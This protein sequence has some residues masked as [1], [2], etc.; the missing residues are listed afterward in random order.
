MI[1]QLLQSGSE[2]SILLV[3][4]LVVVLVAA[5][6]IMEMV[7]E[8][9]IVSVLSGGFYIALRYLQSGPISFNDVLL[10]SFLG[11][12]LY[13]IYSLLASLYKVGST[14]LPIPYQVAK[15]L[16]QPFEY[17]WNRIEEHQKR[18]TYVNRDE[19]KEEEDDGGLFSGVRDDVESILDEQIEEAEAKE[20]DEPQMPDSFDEA[21]EN[22]QTEI[23][24]VDDAADETDA[25]DS[26]S[27]E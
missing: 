8:T 22:M 10:F 16:I 9:V 14:V 19:E 3:L 18:K 6:K 15:T 4:A 12:S 1:Q 23:E 21:A 24:E 13:M 25:D 11:A 26:S 20:Q 7:F 17:A 5:F 2:I 27:G